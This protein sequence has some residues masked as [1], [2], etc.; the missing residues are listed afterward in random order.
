MANL[1]K[2]IILL[3]PIA[4]IACKPQHDEGSD[5]YNGSF[6]ASDNPSFEFVRERIFSPQCV[7]C[8]AHYSNYSSVL[9]ELVQ[10][11]DS[12]FNGR[13]P[14]NASPLNIELKADLLNWIEAGAPFKNDQPP[15]EADELL[16]NWISIKENI[17]LPHCAICH[18]PN[19]KVPWVDLTSFEA[20]QLNKEL[21]FNFQSPI[22]SYIIELILD[23][24]EPMPP[25]DS[26]IKRLD[27]KQIGVLVEWIK[28]GAPE[29]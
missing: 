29:S 21:L 12:V 9:K 18:N 10:I 19:G 3:L 20:I 6:K 22:N 4:L 28:N 17:F 7:K 15:P 1:I 24:N 14:K 25:P 2:L 8:H 16:P 26:N 5:N 27:Q 13:M 23:S 11:K